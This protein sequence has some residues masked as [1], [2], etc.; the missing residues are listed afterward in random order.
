M[1][2]VEIAGVEV[3]RAEECLVFYRTTDPW[4]GLSTAG[5]PYP[6]RLRNLLIESC[7]HLYQACRFPDEPGLQRLVLS[8]ARPWRAKRLAYQHLERTRPDWNVVRRRIMYWCLQRKLEGNANF[9]NLLL[10]TRERT[11]VQRSSEDLYWGA[12]PRPDG[13]LVGH[14]HLGRLLMCL[15]AEATQALAAQKPYLIKTPEVPNFR[16]LGVPVMGSGIWHP[17]VDA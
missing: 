15:R 2:S 11:L 4:G 17:P 5:Y 1:E 9:A 6:V 16:L 8:Q 14:N 3:W 12:V 10:A 13:S 7:E